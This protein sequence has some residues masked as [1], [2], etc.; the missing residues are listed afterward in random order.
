MAKKELLRSRHFLA[1]YVVPPSL[2]LV[3]LFMSQIKSLLPFLLPSILSIL[4]RASF[5]LTFLAGNFM[6][7]E[8]K[9]CLE[10]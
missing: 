10:S 3:L 6:H 1:R 4:F 5:F 7:A 8:E 9:D 2:F